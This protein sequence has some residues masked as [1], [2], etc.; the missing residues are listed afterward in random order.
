MKIWWSFETIVLMNTTNPRNRICW[1]IMA[2]LLNA[3]AEKKTNHPD[4]CHQGFKLSLLEGRNR[5]RIFDFSDLEKS[6]VVMTTWLVTSAQKDK[7]EALA[8]IINDFWQRSSF[9]QLNYQERTGNIFVA[10]IFS[11]HFFMEALIQKERNGCWPV[12]E[13]D[14][15]LWFQG[16]SLQGA[17]I[18]PAM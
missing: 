9:C 10:A 4:F 12:L 11:R 16:I 6:G 13:M 15:S 1:R 3:F 18:F 2:D 5:W 17:L 14:P 7:L 8:Q